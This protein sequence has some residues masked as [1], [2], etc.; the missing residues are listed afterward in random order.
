MQHRDQL[1]DAV[2][3]AALLL[4]YILNHSKLG[5]W[6]Q[7]AGGNAAFADGPATFVP[8]ADQAGMVTQGEKVGIKAD[9]SVNPDD[10]IEDIDECCDPTDDDSD[11][12]DDIED[13][14]EC[15]DPTY[16]DSDTDDDIEDTDE[17]CDPTYDDSDTDDES[18]DTD[19]CC[20]S[21]DD[22]SDTDAESDNLWSPVYVAAYSSSAVRE[23]L[24]DFH[25]HRAP[26]RRLRL[27]HHCRRRKRR[28]MHTV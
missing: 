18:E 19:E 8:A 23:Q 6:I 12:D 16:D 26:K 27:D 2:A 7:A 15:C 9:E 3:A 11:T 28:R 13:T 14:D 4:T 21:T 5:N 24:K 25:G 20:D 10:D 22:D 1:G 17:C